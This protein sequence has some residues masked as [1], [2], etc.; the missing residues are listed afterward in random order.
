VLV[1]TAAFE[2]VRPATEDLDRRPT[3]QPHAILS[4]SCA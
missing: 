2:F 3:F 4:E 1:T